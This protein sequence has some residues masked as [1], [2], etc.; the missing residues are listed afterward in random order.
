[1]VSFRAAAHLL[2]GSQAVVQAG[3]SHQDGRHAILGTL[4]RGG[5]SWPGPLGTRR[6]KPFQ[7]QGP[8][9]LSQTTDERAATKETLDA[10]LTRDS[11]N[12][13]VGTCF[14]NQEPMNL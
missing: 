9:S 4:P 3:A 6:A 12:S 11:R 5:S 7:R 13:F 8:Y 14:H 10:F 2:V 1:M